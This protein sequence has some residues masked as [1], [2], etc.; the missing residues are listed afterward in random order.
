M[1]LF[2]SISLPTRHY[3]NL[4]LFPLLIFCTAKDCI[5]IEKANS[6]QPL[7]QSSC[8][9]AGFKAC[10]KTSCIVNSAASMAD[11]W[12]ICL[13]D[14]LAPGPWCYVYVWALLFHMYRPWI[15]FWFL[16]SLFSPLQNWWH[17]L[18]DTSTHWAETH[19]YAAQTDR[20]IT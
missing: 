16:P 5:A 13:I 19:R 6:S 2:E 4:L 14:C 1:F 3:T 9:R 18:K 17:T 7:D 20:Y 15:I 8:F 10:H 12:A 11:W